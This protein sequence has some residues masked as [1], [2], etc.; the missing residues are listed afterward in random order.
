MNHGRS[1]EVAEKPNRNPFVHLLCGK[2]LILPGSVGVV[3][4]GRAVHWWGSA[5]LRLQS[6]QLG[7]EERCLLSCDVAR[8][9]FKSSILEMLISYKCYF[10]Q[11]L[12]GALLMFR[13]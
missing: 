6:S 1:G 9:I 10:Y 12:M 3:V 7:A 11:S 4:L 5:L 8:D 13:G 2:M